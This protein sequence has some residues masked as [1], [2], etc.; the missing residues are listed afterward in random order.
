M[1]VIEPTPE[2]SKDL[3]THAQPSYDRFISDMKAK[4]LPG[5]EFLNFVL[6]RCGEVK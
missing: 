2:F 1:Q 4:G 3:K 6:K 5:R